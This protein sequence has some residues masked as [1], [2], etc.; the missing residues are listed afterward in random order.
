[1][2]TTKLRPQ[3]T[4]TRSKLRDGNIWQQENYRII[5]CFASHPLPS[6]LPH[7]FCC[8]QPLPANR[9]PPSAFASSESSVRHVFFLSL[10]HHPCRLQRHC[11]HVAR[12]GILITSI[13]IRGSFRIAALPPDVHCR[14]HQI[15][16]WL[17]SEGVTSLLPSHF[18]GV[19]WC[20]FWFNMR[21]T[22]SAM[23]PTNNNVSH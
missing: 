11:S 15:V 18:G 19:Q 13:D 9:P 6:T 8:P 17:P 20:L 23:P 14:R 2:Q 5:Y 3:K 7:L 4:V 12:P 16:G 10:F 21:T 1:M 22:L